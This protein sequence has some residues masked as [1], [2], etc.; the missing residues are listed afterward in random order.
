MFAVTE[1]RFDVLRD[2]VL[3][4]NMLAKMLYN[5]SFDTTL[6]VRYRSEIIACGCVYLAARRLGI[7]MM[8]QL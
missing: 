3:S 6:C 5:K 4:M 7:G 2:L 8:T 1:M